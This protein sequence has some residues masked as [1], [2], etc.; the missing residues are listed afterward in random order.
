[1]LIEEP[2]YDRNDRGAQGDWQLAQWEVL[3]VGM[4]RAQ[5]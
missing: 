3:P 5:V 1:M 2:P 4:L